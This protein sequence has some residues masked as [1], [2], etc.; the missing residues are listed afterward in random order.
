MS[1]M[2]KDVLIGA[3]LLGTL[4]VLFYEAFEGANPGEEIL[5]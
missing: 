1:T 4:G 3:V 2:R 5:A